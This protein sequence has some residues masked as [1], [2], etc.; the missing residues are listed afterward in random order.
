MV[1]KDV[2]IIT[3][4]AN[5]EL[6]NI[7]GNK[8]P[9]GIRK[10]VIDGKNGMHGIHSILYIF[11]K[12]K[13][14]PIKWLILADEDVI[15]YDESIV[16]DLI[17][18]MQK[19]NITAAGVRD[20]GDISHRTYNPFVFNTFFSIL[21][22][23]SLRSIWNEK[24][25][26]GNQY[27]IPHEFED[28]LKNLKFEYSIDSLFEPYYCFFLWLRRHDKNILFLDSEMLDDEIS[29]AVFFNDAKILVHSWYARSYGVNKNHT[30]RINAL[31]SPSD[32]QKNTTFEYV[33]LKDKTFKSRQIFAK[34]LRKIQMR[35]K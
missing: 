7:T 24:D 8:F 26:L 6:Y 12:L 23:E 4:V 29:N 25:V 33:L 35:L 20:G 17:D 34:Y 16:F 30:D 13:T 32:V 9:R 21:N 2:A 31:V 18:Y 15:F 28:E 1:K 14:E 27:I 5:F 10:Y 22:F 11:K 19:N 3:T